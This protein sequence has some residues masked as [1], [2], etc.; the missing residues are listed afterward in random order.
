MDIHV[1]SWTV[2]QKKKKSVYHELENHGNGKFRSRRCTQ[3]PAQQASSQFLKRSE[4]QGP[5]YKA[6]DQR[7]MPASRS[8]GIR[9]RGNLRIGLAKRRQDKNQLGV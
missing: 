1:K 2:Q 5:S 6:T 3:A 8:C 7:R 4:K 9:K